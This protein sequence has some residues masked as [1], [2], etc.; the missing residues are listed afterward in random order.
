VSRRTC[1]PLAAA[2]LSVATSAFSQDWSR[3]PQTWQEHVDRQ[4]TAA[5]S[6]SVVHA[7]CSGASSGKA[8]KEQ[9]GERLG[10]VLGRLVQSGVS[11]AEVQAYAEESYRLK[12]LALWQSTNGTPC[13]ELTRLRD[14]AR[15]SGY[16]LPP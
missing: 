12:I 13:A 14:L 10:R 1:L 11:P 3:E 7:R 15:S 8:A 6:S 5:A 2:L 4:T 9:S 16:P